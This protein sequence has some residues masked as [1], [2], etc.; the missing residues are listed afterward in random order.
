MKT[1][2]E[3]RKAGNM[4]KVF[5]HRHVKTFRSIFSHGGMKTKYDP[6]GGMTK[7]VIKPKNLPSEHT[8]VGTAYCSDKDNYNKKLGV[9]IAMGRALKQLRENHGVNLENNN[10]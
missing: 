1:V 3:L 5:H 9:R 2:H 7:V 4:V 6:R 10:D 8:V